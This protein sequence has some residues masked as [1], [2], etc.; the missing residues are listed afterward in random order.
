LPAGVHAGIGAAGGRDF[1]R[2]IE[3]FGKR[4]FQFAGDGPQRRLK[5]ESA[6]RGAV[7]FDDGS[8]RG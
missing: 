8:N 3:E 7:V 4:G 5:L 2:S 1:N 6:K